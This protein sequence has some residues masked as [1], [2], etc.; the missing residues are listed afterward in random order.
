MGESI[1]E[2]AANGGDEQDELFPLGSIE[3]GTKTLK[4]L[5]PAG[6]EVRS[7]VSM[8]SAEVPASGGIFDPGFEGKLLVTVVLGKVETVPLREEGR[9]VR[10]KVRQVVEAVHVE[11][12]QA[13]GAGAIEAS[14]GDLLAED[15]KAAGKLLDKLKARAGN[16]LATA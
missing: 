11:R 4:T 3:G 10:W 16:A 8:K 5:I 7:T 14:F 6:S 1:S 13:G 15:A 9:V 2:R 12:V